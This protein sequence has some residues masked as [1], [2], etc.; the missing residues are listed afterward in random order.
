M[1]KNESLEQLKSLAE[2]AGP[3]VTA[4]DIE[5]YG[6]KKTFYFKRISFLRA[7]EIGAEPM[8]VTIAKDGP[9]DKKGNPIPV[10]SIDPAKMPHRNLTLVYESLC[11]KDGNHY[12]EEKTIANLPPDLGDKLFEAASK[13]NGMGGEE[14]IET[15]KKSSSPTDSG[16][17][18]SSSPT[19]EAEPLPN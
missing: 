16:D 4:V 17:I 5:V 13:V 9:T 6:E 19:D 3:A 8:Q 2:K 10:V 1:S 15:A 14:A 12:A 7:R 11:D 18:S